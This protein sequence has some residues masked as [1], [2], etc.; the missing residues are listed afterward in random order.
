MNTSS[1]T[2]PPAKG[3]LSTCPVCQG[4][5]LPNGFCPACAVRERDGDTSAEDAAIAAWENSPFEP[6]PI[7]QCL[8]HVLARCLAVHAANLDRPGGAPFAAPARRATALRLLRVTR[9]TAMGIGAERA[10][11]LAPPQR[12]KI[13]RIL[14]SAHRLE[15]RVQ[16][17]GVQPSPTL[18]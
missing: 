14:E 16:A 6:E 10:L 8:A 18:C 17:G 13:A 2:I 1:D 9:S 3:E 11:A 12:E 7:A 15:D 5:L 4:A